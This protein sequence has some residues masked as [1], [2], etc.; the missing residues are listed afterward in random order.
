MA[1]DIYFGQLKPTLQVLQ[2][3]ALKNE[4]VL[5]SNMKTMTIKVTAKS[6][7]ALL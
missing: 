5:Q 2:N 3:F 1:L 6:W 4:W 7:D